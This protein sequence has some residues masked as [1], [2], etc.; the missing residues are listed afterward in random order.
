MQLLQLLKDCSENHGELA[1]PVEQTG[2]QAAG[3]IKLLFLRYKLL[4]PAN[5]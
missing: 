5:S 3:V 4:A 1:I 2:Q